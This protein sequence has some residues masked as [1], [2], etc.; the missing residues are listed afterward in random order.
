MTSIT[1]SEA[2]ARFS[3]LINLVGVGKERVVIERHNKPLVALVPVEEL[4]AL[5]RL[6]ASPEDNPGL[7][8]LLAKIAAERDRVHAV[9]V[10]TWPGEDTVVTPEEYEH[11]LD[12]LY[13][14]RPPTQALKDLMAADGD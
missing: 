9:D 1:A 3:E 6:A 8:K 4:I 7:R 14:P 11:I 5:D 13:H 12:G 2:R 10:L